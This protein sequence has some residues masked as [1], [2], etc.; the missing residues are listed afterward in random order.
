MF[1]LDCT[2]Q[3]YAWGDL[4]SIPRLLGIEPDGTP[5][6]EL[7]MGAHP[8]APSR[9][10]HADART[11]DQ[12][13][14][15]SPESA[16]GAS[17]VERFGQLPFLFKVLAAAQ[18]LSIQTHPSL[19]QAHAGYTRENEAGLD[20]G[21][22]NRTYRDANH[23]PEL[24]CALTPF[25][26]RVGF[27]TV[28][29]ARAVVGELCEQVGKSN[30]ALREFAARLAEPG[31]DRDV[32]HGTLDYL[33]RLADPAVA[34]LTGELLDAASHVTQGEWAN[35]LAWVARMDR[36]FPG[37]IGIAV[38]ILLNH[39]D[40]SPG[41]ALFL[42]AGNLHAYLR[43]TGVELM[44]NSDN[45]V[46]GGLTGKHIDIDELL[47]VVD[48][49]PLT[50]D[51]QRPTS[52][53]HTYTS[54][55]PE[56]ALT[57]ITGDADPAETVLDAPGPKILLAVSGAWELRADSSPDAMDLTQGEVMFV[58]AAEGPVRAFANGQGRGPEGPELFVAT[59]G[60]SS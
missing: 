28:S 51:V 20:I 50:P 27:R 9:V 43:G 39:V 10:V 32:L 12:Y 41:E 19:Q 14:A 30:G 42:P 52:G 17:T 13:I 25:A 7:W 59:I 23:K 58:E 15:V 26:A 47:D 60:G 29:E 37:D 6:A 48:A 22:P 21:A 11:L 18:P 35:E 4:E 5:A 24:I 2:V 31:T 54:P 56:F 34:K 53:A 36:A 38:G 46:R 8:K 55:V 3:D 45:V 1:R 44:A 33:L 16:L 49:T 57:R 40:L